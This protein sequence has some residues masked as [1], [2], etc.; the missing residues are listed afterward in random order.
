MYSVLDYLEEYSIAPEVVPK[1]GE[2]MHPPLVECP[3]GQ[4]ILPFT[5]VT[6]SFKYGVH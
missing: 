1:G 4:R 6:F 5:P 3:A 2:L